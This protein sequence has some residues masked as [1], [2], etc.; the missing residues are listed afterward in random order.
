MKM[1][2]VISGRTSQELGLLGDGTE[3]K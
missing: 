3:K 2:N 1:N